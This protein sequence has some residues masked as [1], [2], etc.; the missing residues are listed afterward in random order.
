VTDWWPREYG[1]S[2][3]GVTEMFVKF[4]KLLCVLALVAIALVCANTAAM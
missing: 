2:D 4:A 3:L 1:A